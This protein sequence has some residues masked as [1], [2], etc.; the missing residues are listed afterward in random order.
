M[1]SKLFDIIRI[2]F[3]FIIEW[4]Y[5]V[6]G[7]YFVAI[8]LF[9]VLLKIITFPFGIRQQKNSQKQARLR[10]KEN[11]IRK[12]YAGRTDRATQMKMNTEIQELY[13]KENFS[14]LG[15]CLPMLIQ[16]LVL[17]AVYAVV[18]SPLTYTAS[19]PKVENFDVVQ[20][21]KQTAAYMAYQDD[22]TRGEEER[23]AQNFLR[24]KKNYTEADFWDAMK[25]GNYNFYCEINAIRYIRDNQEAF[26]TL[27]NETTHYDVSGNPVSV[28]TGLGVRAEGIVLPDLELFNGFDLGTIP[29][30]SLIKA[31]RVGE[32]LL[33]IIPLITLITAYFGQSLTRKYTY[34]PQQN[35]EMQSQMRMMNLFM[36][37]FSLYISFQ[38]PASVG[39]YWAVQNILNPIQQIALSK[40]FPIPEITPEEMK[41]AER[42][43][44]GKQKKAKK[45]PDAPAKKRKS[46]VYDD[47]D[48]VEEIVVTEPEQGLQEKAEPEEGGAIEKAPLKET[49]KKEKKKDN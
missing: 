13:Q 14:Q 15:G 25:A 10:P 17:I 29:S 40:M 38:V 1:F 36:P 47:D 18:R 23:V 6:S 7:S 21:V 5:R 49:K 32:K 44:A 11:V 37:L 42:L 46:L 48:D 22:L 27:Y 19:L 43:Y 34:Q 9:A 2:P 4:L 24:I 39:I 16:L 26:I 31:D 45:D 35:A 33:L 30:F 28:K 12:K 3:G 8:L 20:S 41:E